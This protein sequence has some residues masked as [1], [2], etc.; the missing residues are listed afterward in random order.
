MEIMEKANGILFGKPDNTCG[1]NNFI[2]P[3]NERHSHIRLVSEIIKD[4]KIK[5][6]EHIMR[7]DERDPLFQCTFTNVGTYNVYGR[8]RVGRP[9][10]HWTETPVSEALDESGEAEYE[11]GHADQI[12]ALFA[13]AWERA[14]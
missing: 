13:R 6:L 3:S 12:L 11:R 9:R 10:G 2:R 14:L 7:C 1:W 8:R 4:K 5:L